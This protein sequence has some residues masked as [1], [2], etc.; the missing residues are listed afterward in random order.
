M[1]QLIKYA[2][3]TRSHSR[4]KTAQKNSCKT[5]A[6]QNCAINSLSGIRQ[7]Q[8]CKTN[9]R[10]ELRK[11]SCVFPAMV[12]LLYKSKSLPPERLKFFHTSL[13]LVAQSCNETHHNYTIDL[14]QFWNCKRSSECE[15]VLYRVQPELK[16]CICAAVVVGPNFNKIPLL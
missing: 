12:I 14:I 16:K 1:M 4:A 6:C 15:I 10:P 7:M 2:C 9:C 13:A 8:F 3:D 11:C 5:K